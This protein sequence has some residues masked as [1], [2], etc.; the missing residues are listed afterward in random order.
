MNIKALTKLTLLIII[1]ASLTIG[2]L[3]SYMYVIGYYISIGHKL[4]ENITTLTIENATFN[5]KNAEQFTITILNPSCSKTDATITQIAIRPQGENKLYN[6][7]ITHPLSH[8]IKKGESK[9]FTCN[10]EWG[11]HAGKTIEIIVFATPKDTSGATIQVETDY[12]KI[13]IINANFN[14]AK[15]IKHFTITIQNSPQSTIPLNITEIWLD[16][17]AFQ[18]PPE[19]I[20]TPENTTLTTP[21]TINPGETKTFNCTWDWTNF[22]GT[23]HTIHIKTL[24]G[25]KATYNTAKLPNPLLL[26]IPKV[27]FNEAN[28]NQFNVTIHNSN[29][30]GTYVHIKSIHITTEE[31]NSTKLTIKD[32]TLPYT[33]Y[34]G[35]NETF[36]CIWDWTDYRNKPVTITAHTTQG[37]ISEPNNTITPPY[38]I[39]KIIGKPKF[40]LTD[41][42]HFNIT[43][44]N[45]QYSQRAAN[46]TMIIAGVNIITK[47]DVT[48]AL[49]YM[50]NPGNKTELNCT[51]AWA[52]YK[53]S[54]IRI[55]V[56]FLDVITLEEFQVSCEVRIPAVELNIT[57]VNFNSTIGIQYINVTIHNSPL[58][59]TAVNITK[60]TVTLENGT[61][62]DLSTAIKHPLTPYA[63]NPGE[64]VTFVCQWDWAYFKGANIT[65]TV[66]TLEEFKF[67]Y[68]CKVP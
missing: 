54:Y 15:S 43:I 48:P 8:T 27:D 25:Y 18:I 26:T 45:S 55:T 1:F 21:Y 2:A 47:D 16:R 63:L 6:A 59:L 66:Y 20:T 36:Q 3:L 33:L 9:T 32:K 28:T 42:N 37:F 49:P 65:V 24:E 39:L 56:H 14:P 13:E 60:I 38:V 62:L 61:I 23:N 44:Q 19:N 11:E 58:S 52:D 46:I 35:E 4:P 22:Q 40:N 7:T 68:Q 17:W 50:L 67:S 12:V 34:P 64:T 41:T 29:T 53:G 10:C 31:E 30:S 57:K 51:Y 5:P